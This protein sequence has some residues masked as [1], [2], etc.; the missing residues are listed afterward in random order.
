MFRLKKLYKGEL[1]QYSK[2]TFWGLFNRILLL[3][4]SFIT[5]ILIA[6]YLGPV[7]FGELTYFISIIAILM[8]IVDFGLIGIFV[9]E[10]VQNEQNNNR[11]LGSVF[12]FKFLVALLLVLFCALFSFYQIDTFEERCLFLIISVS[13]IFH[14]LNSLEF[15]FES[16]VKIG[17]TSLMKTL[18]L[19]ISALVKISFIYFN[20]SLWYFGL[21]YSIEV[22]L[23][24]VSLVISFLIEKESF[25]K[26]RF[27]FNIIRRLLS[28]S[29]LLF[30][31][32]ISAIVYFKIDQIMLKKLFTFQ[33]L[34]FYS[35]AIKFSEAWYFLP[36]IIT[37]ALFPALIKVKNDKEKYNGRFQKL[38][39]IL[40][41]ASISIAIIVSLLSQYII[42]LTYGEAYES[43][44]AIL[45]IHVWSGIFV[46]F[47]AILSKW[48]IVE[49]YYVYSLVVQL[50]GAIINVV[51]NLFLIPNYG[52]IGA[53]YA[54][55]ISYTFS[56]IIIIAILPKTRKIAY[57][58]MKSFLI[59]IRLVNRIKLFD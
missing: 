46:F 57:I 26:W 25:L 52:G 49:E 10:L 40:F 12:V 41:L 58:F 36:H 1:L 3:S 28:K 39:D 59:P 2:S 42:D 4:M 47:S 21:A 23:V 6:R 11:I 45:S 17:K 7:K 50:S 37:S 29:W 18:F 35:A 33:E 22:F 16:K 5:S 51:L 56:S 27:D 15:W 31:S 44:A 54:T 20:F 53:A 9:K 13:L 38:S 30:L 19:F 48:L 8:P 34:G 14:P 55:L 32:G 24:G 43:S